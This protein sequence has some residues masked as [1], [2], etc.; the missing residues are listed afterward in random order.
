MSDIKR[1]SAG[2]YVHLLLRACADSC[3]EG[4]AAALVKR[5]AIYNKAAEGGETMLERLLRNDG[6]FTEE[7]QDCAKAL[8]SFTRL[9]T[10]A[11]TEVTATSSTSVECRIFGELLAVPSALQDLAPEVTDIRLELDS[12]GGSLLA[13]EAI[14]AAI[15]GRHVTGH[16]DGNC[17]SAAA[18]LLQNCDHRTATRHSVLMIHSPTHVAVGGL[19]ELEASLAVLQDA[20][21]RAYTLLLNR[22]GMPAETVTSWFDGRDH[23][24]NAEGALAHGLIDEIV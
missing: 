5:A 6:A 14:A 13:S 4:V 10:A 11:S 22:T 19:A 17:L 3:P 9:V 12:V 15:S 16:V 23:Y 24:F 1:L 21:D 18:F 2:L 8:E 20:R 7:S